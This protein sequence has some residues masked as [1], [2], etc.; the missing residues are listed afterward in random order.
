MITVGK[1]ASSIIEKLVLEQLQSRVPEEWVMKILEVGGVT[2]DFR[3][4]C[5]LVFLEGL[6]RGDKYEF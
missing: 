6:I 3:S 2:T 1:N 4:V 5:L